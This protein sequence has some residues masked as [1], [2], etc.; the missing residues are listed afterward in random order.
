MGGE[1]TG[2]A[3]GL[4][5][6]CAPS[7]FRRSNIVRALHLSALAA[8]VA[9]AL[10]GCT[11][12]PP[13]VQ[14]PPPCIDLAGR[15]CRVA[16]DVSH[17]ATWVPDREDVRMH[18]RAQRHKRHRRH[19]EDHSVVTPRRQSALTTPSASEALTPPAKWTPPPAPPAVEQPE[20]RAAGN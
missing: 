16:P 6:D 14:A 20:T 7:E 9:L 8:A 18:R 3:E 19:V 4:Q 15:P 10:G 5:R 11:R 1:E 17:P 2:H 13:P 12:H